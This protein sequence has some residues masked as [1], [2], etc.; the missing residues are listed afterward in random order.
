[1]AIIGMGTVFV[2]LTVLIFLTLLMSKI[3]THFEKQ[4]NTSSNQHHKII[5]DQLLTKIIH[6]AIQQHRATQQGS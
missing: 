2:F 3:V 1:M 4:K 6:T 5:S